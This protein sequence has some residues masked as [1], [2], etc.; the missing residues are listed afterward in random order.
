MSATKISVR[1]HKQHLEILF[2]MINLHLGKSNY[3]HIFLKK[4]IHL[5]LSSLGIQRK[6]IQTKYITFFN[7]I[8]GVIILNYSII[9]PCCIWKEMTQLQLQKTL[10]LVCML[11]LHGRHCF[12]LTFIPLANRKSDLNEVPYFTFISTVRIQY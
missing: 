3:L 9:T 4:F 5:V 7:C 2:F 12:L 10:S 6:V 11:L 1:W 8:H